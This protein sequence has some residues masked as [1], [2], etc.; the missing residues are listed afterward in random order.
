MKTKKIVAGMLSLF[1][2]FGTIGKISKAKPNK[3][4][5]I[6]VKAE[7]VKS[8]DDLQAKFPNGKYWNHYVNDS[9]QIG[10]NLSANFNN[11]FC[12][13]ISDTP[14][15]SHSPGASIGVY[16]CN[17]FEGAIQCCGFARRLAYEAYGTSINTW[18]K[19]YDK[20]SLKPGDVLHYS[21]AGADSTYGHWVMVIGRSDNII[22][23][24]ECNSGG[25]CLISYGRT[26]DLNKI[27]VQEIR[28]APS[29]L[30]IKKVKQPSKPAF[31][32]NVGNANEPTV[33]SW[34]QCSDT[35]W[36]DVY[37]EDIDKGDYYKV[38][39]GVKDLSYK[40]SLPEGNYKVK[41]AACNNGGAYTFSD[42]SLS[43][44]FAVKNISRPGSLIITA[45]PK[46]GKT[47]YKWDRTVKA[48]KVSIVFNNDVTKEYSIDDKFPELTNTADSDTEMQNKVVLNYYDE[49]GKKYTDAVYFY[50]IGDETEEW[51]YCSNLP[52]SAANCKV[53]YQQSES[54]VDTK[55]PGSDWKKGSLVK[56]AYENSGDVYAST[57][58]LPTSETRE[59]VY[60]F[61]YHYCSGTTGNEVNYEF[62]SKFNHYDAFSSD[63]SL[64]SFT[65]VNSGLDSAD[66]RYKWYQLNWSESGAKAT[67]KDGVTCDGS[68]GEHG[69][70]SNYWYRQSYYQDKKLVNYYEYFAPINSWSSEK[71]DYAA[72]YRFSS[73]L[74][75]TVKGDINSDGKF[76]VADVVLLQ[77][78]L[79]AVPDVELADWKAG[80]LCEDGR[81]D[82]F[83]LCLM[84]RMLVENS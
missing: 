57:I 52:D 54:K 61:Y 62:T 75:A 29:E 11:S 36:Y 76:N 5:I 21:G 15:Y 7:S 80:D 17:A 25:N 39:Y 77:K 30:T 56:S 84:K 40:I 53:E 37:V 23:L 34:K 27:T 12:D 2:L 78:W 70:R 67:C 50:G 6:T 43:T 35:D 28:S 18:S 82:V 51:S 42:E 79:L 4:S 68:Y 74:S 8:L 16:D 58:E 59:L 1:V 47:T 69:Y 41:V 63:H 83:D 32:I 48:S 13:A 71:N 49:N 14:C 60:Y 72:S 20:Y 81:L 44:S 9:S 22:T 33:I 3:I 24:G 46:T 31:T 73:G 66:N 55:S 38:E 65:I 45:N 64:G 10:D 26:L 19:H